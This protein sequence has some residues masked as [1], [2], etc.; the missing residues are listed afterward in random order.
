M[1][2]NIKG[3]LYYLLIFC[4]H[5]GFAQKPCAA[6]RNDTLI[7]F[8]VPK[9]QMF[10]AIQK[11]MD[12]IV[13]CLKLDSMDSFMI[14][15]P[16]YTTLIAGQ[17]LSGKFM[18]YGPL[19]D[20][21]QKFRNKPA[22]QG[23]KSLV[24]FMSE[25][26][27]EMIKKRDWDELESILMG[28]VRDSS[29][30]S[31]TRENFFLSAEVG[32]TYREFFNNIM[33]EEETS[34][35]EFHADS[36]NSLDI[37]YEML[38]LEEM[39]AVAK[40]EGKPLLLYFTGWAVVNGYKM[41]EMLWDASLYAAI[42]EKFTPFMGR[43]DDR[44]VITNEQRESLGVK[45]ARIKTLGNYFGKIQMDLLETDRQPVFAIV[46]HTGEVIATQDYTLDSEEFIN[47][48]NTKMD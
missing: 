25:N 3:L 29:M 44:E 14:S 10:E 21:V 16:V 26:E 2:K 34:K 17:V 42:K 46:S 33:D 15:T 45:D 13:N 18:T 7:A 36:S 27:N 8:K 9:E 12:V 24:I 41:Q 4:T 38:P 31:K 32:K 6:I 23:M 28:V 39:L 20:S 35:A 1:R 43:V 30:I 48:L 40:K 37:F 19:F 5:V 47:F 11:D 22:F